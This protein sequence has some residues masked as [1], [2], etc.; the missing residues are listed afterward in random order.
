MKRKNKKIL[1]LL[2]IIIGLAYAVWAVYEL[3]N[4]ISRICPAPVIWKSSLVMICNPTVIIYLPFGIA[5]GVISTII[6]IYNYNK[7]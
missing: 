5:L 6:G 1:S 2:L 3:I 4:S 7:N